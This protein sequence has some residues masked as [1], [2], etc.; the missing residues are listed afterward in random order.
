M[1]KKY[2]KAPKHSTGRII[3]TKTPYGSTSDMIVKDEE[4]LSKVPVADFCILLKDDE[5]YYI[6]HKDRIDDGL[7]DPFRYCESYRKIMTE[8][9]QKDLEMEQTDEQSNV[10]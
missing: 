4:I 2:Y 1:A 5:G 10:A 6:T 8:K 9:I 7:A 3:T